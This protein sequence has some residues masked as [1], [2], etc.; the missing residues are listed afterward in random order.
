MTV[1][2]AVA[3]STTFCSAL[4][5]PAVVSVTMRGA[6]ATRFRVGASYG[7][8]APYVRP[9]SIQTLTAFNA[10][11]DHDVLDNR[12]TVTLAGQ[13]GR[14]HYK[15]EGATLPGGN[16]DMVMGTLGATY[17]VNRTWSV[18]AGVSVENWDSDVR[19]SFTRNSVNAGV[20]AE[21]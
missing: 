21:L 4:P 1:A 18:N 7:L 20:R 5:S 3:S 15:S 13:Y 17:K 9:Y 14:G 11:V 19:E 16:D 8:Y 2:M 6:S 12:L 10:A